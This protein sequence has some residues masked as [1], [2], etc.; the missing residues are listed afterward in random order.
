MNTY[1]IFG[2]SISAGRMVRKKEAWPNLLMDCL[3][4]K[5]NKFTI[6]YNLSIAGDNTRDV[7][8]RILDESKRRIK[9]AKQ[10]GG[11]ITIIFAIGIN[12]TKIM[13]KNNKPV[14][15]LKNFADNINGITKETKLITSNI[16]FIG[17]TRVCERKIPKEWG[18]SFKNDN[19]KRYNDIVAER[20]RQSKIKFINIFKEMDIRN[21][22]NFLSSD[23]LHLNKAGQK[24]IYT[25]INK[26]IGKNI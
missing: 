8:D 17:L 19:I 2:D 12:D 14:T 6:L 26:K 9:S 11:K 20:C 18:V 3:D 24:L 7:L 15:D 16:Y 5:D 21:A 22:D 13:N 23:G 1:L 25:I 4:K 10:F